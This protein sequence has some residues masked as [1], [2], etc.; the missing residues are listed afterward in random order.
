[1]TRVLVIG[2]SRGIGLETVKALLA[3]GFDVR[4]LARSATLLALDDPRLEKID[5]DALDKATVDRA[6]EGVDAVVQ[7]LGVSFSP[8]TILKGTTLFSRAT[9]VLVDAMRAKGVK[10]LVAVTGAGAGDSRGRLGLIYDT[11]IF[12]LVLKRAYDDKDVQE[13]IVKASGLDWTIARPGI[14]TSGPATGRYQVLTDPN[15]WR[16]GPI[17]R[18]DVADFIAKEVAGRAYLGQTPLL[19]S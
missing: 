17:A 4:A 12:P 16:A 7:S 13:Q 14:L 19:I 9:R 5:G 8:Q 18:A 11:V 2:A 15:T 6:L 1:M 3:R 10:R